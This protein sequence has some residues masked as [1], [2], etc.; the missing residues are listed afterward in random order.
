MERM[1]V[2]GVSL[3]VHEWRGEGRG[4]V[5]T[6][7]LPANHTC[8]QSLADIL[9]PEYRLIAYDLRGRGESD[10]PPK[11]YSLEIH[12]RDVNALLDRLDLKRAGVIG[13]SLGAKLA[14]HFAVHYP[15]RVSKLIL[16]G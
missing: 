13:P 11:G 4:V 2:N 5:G 9:T 14:L 6:H 1:S 3:A 12:A 7:G 10:K 8:W 15:K 16:V